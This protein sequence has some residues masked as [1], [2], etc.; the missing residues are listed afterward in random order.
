[1][2]KLLAVAALGVVG[3]SS[4]TSKAVTLGQLDTFN[5]GTL[6]NW[7]GGDTL[8]NVGTGGPA[9][10]GDK[11][12]SAKTTGSPGGPGS[13]LATD[14]TVQWPGNYSAAGIIDVSVDMLNPNAVVLPMRVVLFGPSGERWTSAVADSV[15]ADGV[16]HHEVFS[17]LQPDL[18]EVSGS[19]AYSATITAVSRLMFRYDPTASSG[20]A[21]FNGSIGIDNV[22]AISGSLTWD[23]AASNN[24]WDITSSNW[25][26]SSGNSAYSNV[27]EVTFNDANP[28][29]TAANYNV[30]LN[31]TVS[32]ASVTVNN[33]S[34]NYVIGGTGGIAGAG[35]LSK[36]GSGNLT[37]GTV[38]T[39]SGGT[40]VSAGALI[41]GASGAL[42]SGAVNVTG[43]TVQ[44]ASSIGGATI[45]SL[46]ISGSG[47][48][49]INN[50][51]VV[52]NYGAGPD[53]IASIVALLNSGFNGGAWNGLG[54]FDSSAVAGN[55]GYTVG[56][57]DA[58]DTG[59]PA[60]LASGTIEVAFTL[61]GD[62][63][64]NHTVNGID[65]GI[66][67]ANFNKTVSRWDQGDFDYNGIVN[68][69]DFT[70]LAANFNKAASNAS[71]IAALEAFAAANGLLAAVPEPASI[72]LI[73]LGAFGLMAR[74]RRPCAEL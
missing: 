49:D 69:I 6:D 63:D 7:D 56:Y 11:Y 3:V 46:S 55:P 36:S 28:S 54:G 61:I 16:W 42:P 50:D 51:H 26:S 52:I 40:N 22:L 2:R 19:T 12:L 20:G 65:F 47:T 9:G 59:N 57:A 74:K 70:A 48:F 66:L 62:A 35:A 4:S 1:M 13:H 15:P 17:L 10:V 73:A 24:L 68:G 31:T 21:V 5:D 25:N 39:Y 43:G 30:T 32:P 53:P 29:S 33:S 67:A 37:L 8:A 14:N 64:L 41:V 38:N 23:N 27:S 72:A 60:G 18:L 44:L 34:G 71:D 58:A 45:S